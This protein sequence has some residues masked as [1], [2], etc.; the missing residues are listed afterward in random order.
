MN[1]HRFVR[2]GLAALLT[3]CCL[4]S[5][6]QAQ[7]PLYFTGPANSWNWNGGNQAN[8]S[9]TPSGTYNQPWTDGSDAYFEGTPPASYAAADTTVYP[10]VVFVGTVNAVN[11]LT[12]SVDGYTLGLYPDPYGPTGSITLSGSAGNITT[13]GGTDTIGCQL[14]LSGSLTKLG[15]GLLNLS[16]R[17]FTGDVTISGPSRRIATWGII[18][19]IPVLW[20]IPRSPTTSMS[21]PELRSCW[22]PKMSWEATTTA[23]PRR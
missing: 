23:R 5:L 4:G 16:A 9:T 11:S 13:S 2:V 10:G 18:Q 19:P 12:F 3:L 1:R 6:A 7:S 22:K 17:E 14:G 15:P 8:W 20:E 21:V